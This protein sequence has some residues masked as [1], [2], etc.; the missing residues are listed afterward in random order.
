M[1]NG[2]GGSS[3]EQKP[4]NP[5]FL[6]LRDIFV[7]AGVMVTLTFGFAALGGVFGLF[8]ESPDL[9][10]TQFRQHTVQITALRAE[11]GR[12]QAELQAL[13]STPDR[14]SMGAQVASLA[15]TTADLRARQQRLE[16]AIMDDPARALQ[17]PLLRRD[18][19]NL[20]AQQVQ[21]VEAQRRDVERLYQLLI[22]LFAALA[23]SIVGPGLFGAFIA[24]SQNR[25]QEKAA[26][27]RET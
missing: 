17:V 22:G 11:V 19:D 3:D 18:L 9:V 8:S 20:I 27:V 13:R 1:A 16:G 10:A 26:A 24:R 25:Q 12:L 14:S 6:W 2:A 23:V 4:G 21:Q 7:F 15:V 5:Q